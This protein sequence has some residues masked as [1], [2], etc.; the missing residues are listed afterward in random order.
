MEDINCMACNMTS[1]DR[2]ALLVESLVDKR[3]DFAG[4]GTRKAKLQLNRL[5]D[6]NPVARALRLALEIEDANIQ[7]KKYYGK[8]RNRNYRK[9]EMLIGELCGVFKE[10]AWAG[11]GIQANK[12]AHP[13]HIV[14]FDIPGCEQIS[15][16]FSPKNPHQYPAYLGAWDQKPNSTLGKLEEATVALLE[17]CAV[18]GAGDVVDEGEV[19]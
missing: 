8:W 10:Q 3:T 18:R 14:Y 4:M 5:K 17:A 19:A 15:F 13:S 11:Y 12:A 16:H 6:S 7:A 1:L 2:R 9:K